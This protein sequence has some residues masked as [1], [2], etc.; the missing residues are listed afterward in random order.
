MKR[1]SGLIVLIAG[2]AWVVSVFALGY[3]GKFSDEE[4]LTDSFRPTFSDTG[5]KQLADDVSTANA[6]A[7]DF[8]GKA[9]P[10]IATQLGVQ[11]A[12]L[13]LSV[14]TQ[15]PSVALGLQQLP[16]ALSFMNDT[17]KKIAD[18]Q[19]NFH[20]V[21]EI[22]TSDQPATTVPWLFVVPGVIAIL[23]GLWALISRGGRI[24][25]GIS[26]LV[27]VVVIVA[28]VVTSIPD[29]TKSADQLTKAF[30]PVFTKSYVDQGRDYVTSI[31]QF[32]SQLTEQVIPALATQ[33]GV[34]ADQFVTALGTQL[35]TVTT[36]LMSMPDILTR[37]SA[38]LDTIEKNID[39]FNGADSIPSAGK[40]AKFVNWQYWVPAALLVLF[41][42]IGAFAPSGAKRD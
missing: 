11:P 39:H 10:A 3:F 25:L 38:L 14:G 16:D 1:F 19:G 9:I 8:Q 31:G 40:S 15:F 27:G 20:K 13:L 37:F 7:T 17:A 22:P 26:A 24:G 5:E 35:P 30:D 32:G 29:K 2:L 23:L 6:F 42:L 41:G 4:K 12:Q 36:G 18:Q 21:D 33:A 28:T 34:P